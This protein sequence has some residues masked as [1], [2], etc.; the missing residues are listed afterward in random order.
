MHIDPHDFWQ[1]LFSPDEVDEGVLPGETGYAAALPDGRKIILPLRILPGNSEKAVAS[2]IV[3]QAS[4]AVLDALADALAEALGQEAPDVVVSVPTLG[5]PLAEGVARRLGHARKVAL[6]MSRK[7]WYDETLSEPLSSITTPDQA[8]RIYL[9]PRML[10][11]LRGKRIV[12]ID[13]VISTG[14]SMRS[15]LRLLKRAGVEPVAVG[16]AMLQGEVWKQNLA[17]D[18]HCPLHGVLA[19]PVLT[20]SENGWTRS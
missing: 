15:V 4:F 20:R 5:L 6:S 3:N 10:S 17:S 7:F 16:V 1:V 11:L 19:T 18:M 8:K 14:S 2:L 13:D 12:V 9:D